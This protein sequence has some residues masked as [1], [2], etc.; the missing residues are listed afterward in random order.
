M[1]TEEQS[2]QIVIEWIEQFDVERKQSNYRDI[3]YDNVYELL[4]KIHLELSFETS[5]GI[6]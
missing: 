6:K 5:E 3:N 1:R 4:E 2:K